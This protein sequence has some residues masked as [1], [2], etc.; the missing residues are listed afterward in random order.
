MKNVITYSRVSTDEQAQQ[1]YS[2]D[3]QN[4]AIV[5]YCHHKNYNVIKTFREDYSAKD[6]GRPE[7]KK[8]LNLI[9]SNRN[10]DIAIDSIVILRPDRYSRNLI[11]SFSETA[12]LAGL[13]CEVEFLEGQVDDASPDALLLKAI[14]YALPQMEN[15]KLSRRSKEGSHK[16]RLTGCWTG[17][18]PMGYCNI[19]IDKN[20]SL[21]PSEYAP[22]IVQGFEKMASGLYSADEVRRWLN[23]QGLKLS[24]NTFPNIIRNIVYTGKIPVKEFKNEPSQVVIG[25]H[26]PLVSDEIFSEANRVLD[27][28]RRN[29]KFHEDKSDL[30]PL[31]GH[32]CC[33]VHNLSLTAGKSKGRYGIYHY[34]LCSVKNKKCK[35]YP[36]D[37]VHDV[38][39]RELSQIQFSANVFKAYHSILER[40]FENEDVE[41][42]RNLAKTISEIEKKNEQK[43]NIQELLRDGKLTIEEYRELKNPIDADLYRL[44][45]IQLELNEQ[46][47]PYKEYINNHIPMLENLLEF[48]QNSS[49][50]VKNKIL[51][52][53]FSEKIHFD[54]NKVAAICFQKP[55]EVL[56]N[57]SKVLQRGK[58]EKEVKKDLLPILAPPAGLE[59][60]TL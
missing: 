52:C 49:G 46:F 34:Y 40:M 28:R 38:V 37:W 23:G 18:A 6:F 31:K 58:K 32:L 55:I 26:P 4:E 41:R 3:Y 56:L 47:S 30:Y 53:I 42:K 39:E 29:M 1:G 48:Y 57:A 60:A 5:R 27:G 20:S 12:K 43:N 2:L 36:V 11:L 8:I 35:R 10:T 45:K 24:K 33:K 44:E 51:S 15:E 21:A 17:L 19:R 22:L 16:A 50:K 7:W 54:E 14:G 13:G 59:P 9:K 25:L